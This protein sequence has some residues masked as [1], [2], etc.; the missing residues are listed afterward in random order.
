MWLMLLA[1]LGGAFFRLRGDDL[2]KRAWFRLAHGREPTE[3]DSATT[4]GRVFW[5]APTVLFALAAAG[6]A[7]ME[8]RWG[9][10]WTWPLIAATASVATFYGASVRLFESIGLGL[11]RPQV[12]AE[13]ARSASWRSRAAVCWRAIDWRLFMLLCMRGVIFIGP[14]GVV[15]AISLNSAALLLVPAGA[16]MG[17][18][19]LLA[20]FGDHVFNIRAESLKLSGAA[21][22]EALFGA[23]CWATIVLSAS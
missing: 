13:L 4:V 15:M 12:V 18:L 6:L 22:G 5:A 7:G 16:M 8:P 17:P 10:L 20:W 11:D 14:L 19:Y 3:A 2:V 9:W 1:P 23:W 21:T